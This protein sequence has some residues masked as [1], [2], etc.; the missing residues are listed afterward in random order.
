MIGSGP[1]H[2]ARVALVAA[3][4]AL[5]VLTGCDS[6]PPPAID[7]AAVTGSSAPDAWGQLAG[8]VAAAKD[9]R[10]SASYTYIPAGGAPRTVSVVLGVDGSW[11]V[12]VPGGGLGGT[13][14]VAVAGDKSGLYQCRLGAVRDCVRLAA[15][16]GD[17]PA[18]YDPMVEHLF[19]D[20][21][22]T[23]RDRSV[24]LSVAL[25]PTLKGVSGTCFSVE[26][27]SASIAPPV[28]PGVYCFTADGLP[29]AAQTARG[30]LVLAGPPAGPPASVPLPAPIVAGAA[31][32]TAAPPTPS[33]SP[34]VAKSPTATARPPRT[35][36]P[37]PSR[38][39]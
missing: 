27:T 24:P 35:P 15:A 23:F 4:A 3:G 34:S 16:D 7:D 21:L 5:A 6:G 22:D 25:V 33:A 11:L 18:A 2:R 17:L 10:F 30:T 32:P 36:A 12:G 9:R 37:T 31:V 26:A 38:T 13:A 1:L 19:T 14:D 8:R 29:T 28:D 39:R 20:W